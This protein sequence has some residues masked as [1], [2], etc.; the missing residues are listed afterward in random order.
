MQNIQVVINLQDIQ[1][2]QSFLN[3]RQIHSWR[4]IAKVSKYD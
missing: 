4:I 3:L 2:Y 1:Q